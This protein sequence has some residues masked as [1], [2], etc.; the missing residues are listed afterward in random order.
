MEFLKFRKTE[1]L[2][3]KFMAKYTLL[4]KTPF[5]R[6]QT[7]SRTNDKDDNSHL[8]VNKKKIL[9]VED[10]VKKKNVL[11]QKYLTHFSKPSEEL[12]SER[13]LEVGHII[14]TH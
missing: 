9:S 12:N 14:S 4:Y 11:P 1:A 5:K 13:I 10:N 6:Y 8:R 7:N 3:W 2:L